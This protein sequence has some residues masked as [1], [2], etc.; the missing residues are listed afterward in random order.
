MRTPAEVYRRS[1]RRLGENDRIRYPADHLECRI[2]PNGHLLFEGK[3][4][5]VGEALALRRIGLFLNA[6]G[7]VEL[8]Y[9][10]LHLGNL[11]FDKE[12]RFRP[13]AYIAPPYLLNPRQPHPTKH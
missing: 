6:K 7:V 2:Q 11:A 1:E 12:G 8:R 13:T 3:S 10:N 5:F 9:A 4:Y